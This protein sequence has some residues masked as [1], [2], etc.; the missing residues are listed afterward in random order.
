MKLSVVVP[1]YNK[2]HTIGEILS[3]VFE[4]KRLKMVSNVKILMRKKLPSF[5]LRIYNLLA[6]LL[7]VER[8]FRPPSVPHFLPLQRDRNDEDD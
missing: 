7:K 2:I 3:R 8:L 4:M 1:V 5:Q 6:P